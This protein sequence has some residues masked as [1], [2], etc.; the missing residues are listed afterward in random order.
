MID[1]HSVYR[2]LGCALVDL[3]APLATLAHHGQAT[4]VRMDKCESNHQ[5]VAAASPANSS[6]DIHV[7]EALCG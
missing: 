2:D 7:W 6:L 3:G 5:A 4:S 1:M